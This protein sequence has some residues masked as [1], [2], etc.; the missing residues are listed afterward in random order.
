MTGVRIFA[1]LEADVNVQLNLSI[2]MMEV[3]KPVNIYV[4]ACLHTQS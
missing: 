1:A 2:P 4:S 3:D